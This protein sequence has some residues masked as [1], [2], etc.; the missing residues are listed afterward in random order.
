FETGT[1]LTDT[2]SGFRMYP[3]RRLP[4][5]FYTN[6]FEFE[7]EVIVRSAWNGVPVKNIPIQVLYD[8]NERVS[9]FR[10]FADFT[11]IS[12]LNTVLV[13]IAILYIHPRNF[14]RKINRKG[15]K[16]F[17]LENILH[18]DDSSLKKSLSVALGVFIGIAPFWG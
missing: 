15:I 13:L 1:K 12:I 18:N 11:R 3:L 2:Q 9:H 10:P 7:I 16:K 8:P 5:R 6:K 4:K 14:I 17:L